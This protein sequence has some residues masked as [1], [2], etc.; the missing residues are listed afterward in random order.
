MTIFFDNLFNIITIHKE[1]VYTFGKILFT[2][3]L[4]AKTLKNGVLFNGHY[5]PPRSS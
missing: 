4:P 3:G 5:L 2:I 1:K